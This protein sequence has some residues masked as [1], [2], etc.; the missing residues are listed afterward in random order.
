MIRDVAKDLLGLREVQAP[1]DVFD[2]FNHL[3]DRLLGDLTTP[4]DAWS[5]VQRL[6]FGGL[7]GCAVL[8]SVHFWTLFFIF[9]EKGKFLKWIVI[10]L[11]PVD[12]LFD[13]QQSMEVSEVMGLPPN[14]HPVAAV[15]GGLVQWEN[16]RSTQ[17]GD[18]PA[19]VSDNY[20]LVI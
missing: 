19:K 10:L 16:H 12:L 4:S 8:Q 9:L 2:Q 14:H 20:P 13:F 3:R 7:E 1:E 17:L 18:F 6:G 5:K 15:A 11:F